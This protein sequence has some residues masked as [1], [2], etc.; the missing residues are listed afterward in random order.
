M[1]HHYITAHEQAQLKGV[2]YF[3]FFDV[4]LAS[5][6]SSFRTFFP[7]IIHKGLLSAQLFLSAHCSILLVAMATKSK[8]KREKSYESYRYLLPWQSECGK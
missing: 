6:G 1:L 4:F 7:G 3:R 8:K 2:C 5:R